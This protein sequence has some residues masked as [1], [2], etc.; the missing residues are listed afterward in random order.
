MRGAATAI[1]TAEAGDRD[2]QIGERGVERA[3]VAVF[4]D[5]GAE[6]SPRPR[7]LID[8]PMRALVFPHVPRE[9][10]AQTAGTVRRSA[11][12]I[13][14]GGKQ[15]LALSRLNLER[16]LKTQP[17]GIGARSSDGEGGG[18]AK[19][20]LPRRPPLLPEGKR[21]IVV[22]SASLRCLVSRVLQALLL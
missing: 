7:Q 19:N 14:A 10:G 9:P 8:M 4:R 12:E 20:H 15:A 3:F 13:I 11:V 5:E 2:W 1:R 16:P 22:L 17:E 6:Y 21:P 18:G